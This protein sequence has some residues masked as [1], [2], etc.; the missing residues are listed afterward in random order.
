MIDERKVETNRDK[1][2]GLEEYAVACYSINIQSRMTS[3]SMLRH[4]MT[5]IVYCDAVAAGA[6]L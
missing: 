5:Y 3:H 1:A 6:V 4:D 2:I